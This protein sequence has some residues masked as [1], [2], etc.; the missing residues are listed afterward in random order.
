MF[1]HWLKI[2]LIDQLEHVR[3]IGIP[4]GLAQDFVERG[5]DQKLCRRHRHDHLKGVGCRNC[6]AAV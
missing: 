4:C 1:K 5:A 3:V 6:K 2:L